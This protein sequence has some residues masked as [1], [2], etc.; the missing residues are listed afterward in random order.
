MLW[1]PAH[2]HRIR[3]SETGD[4]RETPAGTASDRRRPA[5]AAPKRDMDHDLPGR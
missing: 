5:S 4:R 3:R 2:V 1:F